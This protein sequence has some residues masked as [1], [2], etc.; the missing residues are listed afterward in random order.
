MSSEEEDIALKHSSNTDYEI[1]D[2]LSKKKLP[3]NQK[4]KHLAES[5]E[6]MDKKAPLFKEYPPELWKAAYD[7]IIATIA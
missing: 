5:F 3:K 4:S 7:N 6:L 2:F 1:K